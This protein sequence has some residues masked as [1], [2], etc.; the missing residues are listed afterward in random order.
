MLRAHSQ[1]LVGAPLLYAHLLNLRRLWRLYGATSV[2]LSPGFGW[3]LPL[4]VALLVGA[5]ASDSAAPTNSGNAEAAELVEREAGGNNG[6]VAGKQKH[7]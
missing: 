5:W 7:N 2:L 1:L 6:G 3:T 4:T